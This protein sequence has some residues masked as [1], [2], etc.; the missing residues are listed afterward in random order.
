M[1]WKTQ[2]ASR[3][4]VCVLSYHSL[5]LRELEQA[6]PPD[7]FRLQIRK[8]AASPLREL[9]SASRAP[10]YVVDAQLPQPTTGTLIGSITRQSPKS[11]ILVVGERFRETDAF[12]LLRLGVK[13]FVP[14]TELREKLPLALDSV[15]LGGFWVPRALLSRF[16][17]TVVASSRGRL[18]SG[19]SASIS[20]REREVLE[21]LLENL[22]NKEIA[23]RL[24][25]SE[26]TV[27]FHVSNLLSKFA[28]ASRGDLILHCLGVAPLEP[29]LVSTRKLAPIA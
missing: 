5:V 19:L 3:R 22:S 25:I 14:Y 23:G 7:R 4:T 16:M 21:R 26:R 18:S 13:G 6:L 9:E 15:A 29:S 28:L 11:R 2:P 10:L 12:A 27:K 17:D 20:G 24:Y 1:A 8:V